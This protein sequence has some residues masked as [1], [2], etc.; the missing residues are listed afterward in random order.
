MQMNQYMCTVWYSGM[1]F[2]FGELSFIFF[3][4]FSRF[5]WPH[6]CTVALNRHGISNYPA[7]KEITWWQKK[8]TRGKRKN[9]TEK[10]KRLMAKGKNLTSKEKISWQKK[11]PH[12]KRKN[13]TAKEKTPRQKEKTARQREKVLFFL[14]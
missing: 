3:L 12:V 6:I 13:L 14:L 5:V 7:A 4:S 2:F 10:R 8:K 11:K 1:C 9:L